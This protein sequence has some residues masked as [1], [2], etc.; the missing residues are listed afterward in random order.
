MSSMDSWLLP[1]PQYYQQDATTPHDDN[2]VTDS[3][4]RP[5]P[6]GGST[7]SEHG[8]V[9][10]PGQAPDERH[11]LPYS[12]N[13]FFRVEHCDWARVSG[14]VESAIPPSSS[15]HVAASPFFQSSSTHQGSHRYTATGGSR[16]TL[17]RP[18]PAEYVQRSALNAP[19]LPT[20][21]RSSCGPVPLPIPGT[22]SDMAP[23]SG[24]SHARR[25]DTYTTR[26]V[27]QAA[28]PPPQVPNAAYVAGS[29]APLR[30][31]HH[32]EQSWELLARSSAPSLIY[33]PT[34]SSTYASM[35]QAVPIQ[36]TQVQPVNQVTER[37]ADRTT[38]ICGL[39]GCSIP[40][41]D[42][43]VGG[44]R[45]HL[46]D[47]HGA[48]MQVRRVRCTWVRVD[49]TLC[50]REM[51]INSWGKHLAAVHWSSMAQK[52]PHCPRVICRPDAL[53][54]HIDNFHSNEHHSEY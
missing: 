16:S 3:D 52:C 48:Q 43:S 50:E 4:A 25:A 13:S 36:V 28:A 51:D 23:W 2:A 31:Y 46:R 34:P 53:K 54:R 39:L 42:L 47:F 40:L 27:N 37:E 7:I 6:V 18:S 38:T 49:G 22:P 9:P 41:D 33:R 20:N 19:P 10:L 1:E 5:D 26:S 44:Q 35:P 45:R 17:A 14:A 29:Y 24:V 15:S 11:P 30:S 32:G 21:G 8:I 12:A